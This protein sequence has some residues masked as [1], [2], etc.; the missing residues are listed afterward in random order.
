[1]SLYADDIAIWK[2]SSIL[3][4]ACQQVAD[5]VER[6][7]QWSKALKLTLNIEKC[8]ASFFSTDTHEAKY[9]PKINV[10]GRDLPYNPTPRFLGV[11]FDRMLTFRPHIDNVC[12]T[13]SDRCRILAVLANKEWGWQPQRLRTVHLAL[14]RSVLTYAAAGWVP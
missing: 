8:E 11:K 2:S 7:F 13:V 5:T 3:T 6:V 14:C 9:V 4:D 1:M 12:N 10:Q